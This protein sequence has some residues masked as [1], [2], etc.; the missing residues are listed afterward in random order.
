MK[1]FFRLK[2]N[3][4]KPLF[5][6]KNR[7]RNILVIIYWVLI[8]ICFFF[9]M[10]NSNLIINSI[11]LIIFSVIV[12]LFL[13]PIK[14]LKTYIYV[15]AIVFKESGFHPLIKKEFGIAFE[16]IY[17]FRLK[18]VGLNL[19]WVVFKRKNGKSIRKLLSLSSSEL[20]SFIETFK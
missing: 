10:T 2:Q 3:M 7:L 12:L 16:N 13:W 11:S 6:Y 19:C 18:R 15:D 17:D 9:I 5:E 8:V 20:S 14:L 4:E 1:D